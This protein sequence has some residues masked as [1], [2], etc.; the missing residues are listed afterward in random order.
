MKK[1]I[2]VLVVAISFKI[3]KAR[4]HQNGSPKSSII[5][6]SVGVSLLYTT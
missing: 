3:S 6:T 2:I 5:N 1:Y 4:L